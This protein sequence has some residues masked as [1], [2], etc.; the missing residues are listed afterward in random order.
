MSGHQ[1]DTCGKYLFTKSD[2]TKHRLY[3]AVLKDNDALRAENKR[4]QADAERYRW[5]RKQPLGFRGAPSFA[6]VLYLP[7]HDASHDTLD[8]IVDAA[9]AAKEG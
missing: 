6:P 8:K 4:L 7:S 2:A 3:E 5:M 9:L 1:C